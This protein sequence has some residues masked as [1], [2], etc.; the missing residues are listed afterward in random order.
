[1]FA[2]PGSPIAHNVNRRYSTGDPAVR[3]AD[4]E[5]V[6]CTNCGAICSGPDA[7]NA[8]LPDGDIMYLTPDG[9]I[10]GPCYDGEDEYAYHGVILNPTTKEVENTI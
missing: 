2:T 8:A 9:L 3:I 1:V 4:N 6:S 10:C 5:E 7:G